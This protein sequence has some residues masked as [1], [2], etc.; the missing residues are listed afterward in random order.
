MRR[1]MLD[2]RACWSVFN[3]S[4]DGIMLIRTVLLMCVHASSSSSWHVRKAPFV[5]SCS[6]RVFSIPRTS[7]LTIGKSSCMS[8]KHDCFSYNRI[9]RGPNQP[10]YY[11][12]L[13]L[14][15]VSAI[16]HLYVLSTDIYDDYN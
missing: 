8:S 9:Y 7:R 5:G 12:M 15:F 1:Y 3:G 4:V 10:V 14:M 13:V 2:V 11:A 16:Y 6:C